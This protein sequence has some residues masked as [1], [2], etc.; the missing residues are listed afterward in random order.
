MITDIRTLL[1]LVCVA[2]ACGGDSSAHADGEGS[3]SGGA[4]STTTSGPITTTVNMTMTASPDSTGADTT[5]GGGSGCPNAIRYELYQGA[6]CGRI[7]MGDV[8]GNGHDDVLVFAKDP[9]QFDV[10]SSFVLHTFPG[11]DNA[12]GEAKLH[13]CI[14]APGRGGGVVFDLNGDERLDPLWDGLR[15]YGT[16]S[17]PDLR[18]TLEKMIRGPQGGYT[19]P[20]TVLSTGNA[21]MPFIVGRIMSQTFGIIAITDQGIQSFVGTGTDLGLEA[22]ATLPLDPIPVIDALA[23]IEIDAHQGTDLAGIGPDG[24]S[25]WPGSVDGQFSPAFV[26]DLGGTYTYLERTDLEL[27]GK[28]ELVVVGAGE[29]VAVIKG[30]GNGGVMVN[31]DGMP[32]VSA[33]MTL[34]KV[35]TDAFP[36]MLTIDGGNLVYHRGTGTGGFVVD[37]VVL[38]PVGEVNGIGFGKIDDNDVEDFVVCDDAGLLILYRTE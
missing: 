35:D 14:D 26:T 4:E 6:G 31:T 25:V 12:V 18:P 11:G 36:D 2:A 5:G 33:P 23:T 17:E 20:G 22:V 32:T 15:N 24:L 9:A 7:I 16:V 37:P 10:T 21:G 29:P 19:A 3:S 1:A 30:D 8:D 27:N 13:C 38:A 28:D 34:V